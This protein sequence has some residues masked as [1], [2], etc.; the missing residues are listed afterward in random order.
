M[1]TITERAEPLGSSSHRP[2]NGLALPP[3]AVAVGSFRTKPSRVF[4]LF[5]AGGDGCADCLA[6]FQLSYTNT[7]SAPAEYWTTYAG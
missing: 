6:S 1:A 3:T 5:P 2:D 4:F 7:V